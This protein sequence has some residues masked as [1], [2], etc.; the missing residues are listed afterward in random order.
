VPM[1][2]IDPKTKKPLIA[3]A[4]SLVRADTMEVIAPI[5]DGIPRFVDVEQNYAESFGFQWKRWDNVRSD[6]RSEGEGLRETVKR[7][8]HFDEYPIEGKTILE[9]G[10]GGGDDTEILLSFPFS[11]IYSFDISTAVERAAKYLHDPR[12]VLLQASIYDIPYP[13][14]SFDVV[15][16]HRVL[17]H[18][19]DPKAALR[20]VCRKVKEGGILFAHSYRRSWRHMSEWRYKYR[21]FTKRL[22]WKWL[23]GFLDRHGPLMDRIGWRLHRQNAL[24][25]VLGYNFFPFYL[26]HGNFER[27]Q[28]IELEKQITFDA[29]TPRHDHPMT[30]GTFRKIIESEGFR[31]EHFFQYRASPVFCTAVRERIP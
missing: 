10:M 3:C 13:D 11:E 2:W 6:T 28:R 22:S 14:Y 5:I 29:L 30:S 18:T 24:T 31:I 12:L 16:C 17:Q 4:D 20:C 21:W 9:C 8:T 7:R 19:P 15:Y 23:A 27:D 1:S 26:V 25:R